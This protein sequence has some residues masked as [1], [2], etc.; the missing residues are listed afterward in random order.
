MHD[1]RMADRNTEQ[2]SGNKQCILI[3]LVMKIISDH[4]NPLS[5]FIFFLPEAILCWNA[6]SHCPAVSP[7]L[8]VSAA[9]LWEVIF[10]LMIILWCKQSNNQTKWQW[11]QRLAA[12]YKTEMMIQLP[13]GF[14]IFLL[15]MMSLFNTMWS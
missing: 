8:R 10:L 2:V 1:I 4:Y 15:E 11:L 14:Q 9:K 13:S 3:H 6:Y 5:V 7:G 12:L